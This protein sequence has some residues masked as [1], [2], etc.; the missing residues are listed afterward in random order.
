MRNKVCR[1]CNGPLVEIDRYGERLVGCLAC[2]RWGH[3][4]DKKLTLKMLEEDLEALRA[5][6]RKKHPLN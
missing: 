2:N 6:E 4:T 1:Y 5:L 3:P